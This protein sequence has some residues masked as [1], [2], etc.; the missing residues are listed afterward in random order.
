[1]CP[2]NIKTTAVGFYRLIKD[3]LLNVKSDCYK[4]IQHL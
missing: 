4:I 2:I 3:K 1:M